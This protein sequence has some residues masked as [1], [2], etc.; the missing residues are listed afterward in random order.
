MKGEYGSQITTSNPVK[1]YDELMSRL[2][3]AYMVG[4][5]MAR[6]FRGSV[7]WDLGLG[8]GILRRIIITTILPGSMSGSR[9]SVGITVM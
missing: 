6:W 9:A 2:A 8:R 7:V 4:L 5:I 1:L 3:A